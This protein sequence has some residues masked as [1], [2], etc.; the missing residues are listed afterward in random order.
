MSEPN[1]LAAE[2]VVNKIKDLHESMTLEER[3]ILRA[4]LKQAEGGPLED[5][6]HPL[7]NPL[8]M[9]FSDK[10]HVPLGAGGSS[11]CW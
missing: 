7:A 8:M 11:G 1:R 9:N 3:A 6:F 4:L 2:G 5:E 10:L